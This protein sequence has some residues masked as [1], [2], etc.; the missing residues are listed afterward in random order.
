M[1]GINTDEIGDILLIISITALFVWWYV[2]I[3]LSTAVIKVEKLV[4]HSIQRET[5]QLKQLSGLTQNADVRDNC[6]KALFL[7]SVINS[8]EFL[9][10]GL[11]IFFLFFGVS[12]Y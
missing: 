12:Q 1:F 4:L 10:F 9:Y 5:K 8:I 3:S 11:L 2:L 7:L 6:Q